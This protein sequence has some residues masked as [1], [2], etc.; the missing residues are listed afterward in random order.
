M[1]AA[2]SDSR[3]SQLSRSSRSC[4]GRSCCTTCATR[5]RSGAGVSAMA[6]ATVD[7]EQGGIADGRQ[8][9][10]DHAVRE[11]VSDIVWR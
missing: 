10:P 1:R 4:W 2:A 5:S 7:S 9:D 3:C 6:A 8:I 11:A